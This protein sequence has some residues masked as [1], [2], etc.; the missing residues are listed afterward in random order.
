[1]SIKYIHT[2][3]VDIKTL[4]YNDDIILTIVVFLKNT[5]VFRYKFV[6]LIGKKT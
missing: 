2:V 4:Y 1:M 6:I 5:Y 3:F